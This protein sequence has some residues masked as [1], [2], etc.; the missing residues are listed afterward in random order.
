MVR[1]N[2]PRYTWRSY[3]LVVVSILVTLAMFLLDPIASA[4]NEGA[5]LP[6]MVFIFIGTLVSVIGIIFVILSKKE[7]SKVALIALAITLFNCGVIAFFLF[8]GLMYT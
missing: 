6:M 8:V 1:M 4:T 3:S 2:E 5:S 7:Q